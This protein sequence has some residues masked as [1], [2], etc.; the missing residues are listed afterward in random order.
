MVDNN[1][2]I[3]SLS[4][5]EYVE[6]NKFRDLLKKPDNYYSLYFIGS[7][8]EKP[9]NDKKN[10]DSDGF[11]SKYEKLSGC[12]G[13]DQFELERE[14]AKYIKFWHSKDVE[15]QLDYKNDKITQDDFFNEENVLSNILKDKYIKKNYSI[16]PFQLIDHVIGELEKRVFDIELL[17]NNR[18]P[19]LLLNAPLS[20]K[21]FIEFLLNNDIEEKLH[22]LYQGKNSILGYTYVIEKIVVFDLF[23]ILIILKNYPFYVLSRDRLEILFKSLK[24]YK[25]FPYPIGSIGGDLFNLLIHE[26]YLPGVS[27]FQEIRKTLLLDI[28]DPNIIDI[29]PNDFINVVTFEPRIETIVKP[30][31]DE[32]DANNINSKDQLNSPNTNFRLGEQKDLT[33]TTMI[34]FAS[35]ILY[36]SEDKKD[37]EKEEI[38]FENILA[39]FEKRLKQK[40]E[41]LKNSKENNPNIFEKN[42]INN[43]FNLID[44]GLESNFSKFKKEV[45]AFNDE[46]ISKSKESHETTTSKPRDNINLRKFLYHNIHKAELSKEVKKKFKPL[47]KSKSLI[48]N[49]SQKLSMDKRNM[50]NLKKGEKGNK[51]LINSDE[52]EEDQIEDK[53]SLE[54]LENIRILYEYR[55]K[56]LTEKDVDKDEVLED[57]IKNFAEMRKKYFKHLKEFQ[58]DEYK[59]SDDKEK[60][61]MIRNRVIN[62][63]K[64]SRIKEKQLTELYKQK[65]IVKENQLIYFLKNLEVWECNIRPLF[66][67]KLSDDYR[68]NKNNERSENERK[69]EIKDS[70]SVGNEN[71]NIINALDDN[72]RELASA[73]R[74]NVLSQEKD[75]IEHIL[76]SNLP[77]NYELYLIPGEIKIDDRE[78]PDN[79]LTKYIS[80]QDF[81][82]KSII[83]D[84]YW[85]LFNKYKDFNT[86]EDLRKFIDTPIQLYLKES[87]HFFNLK[88]F[89]CKIKLSENQNQTELDELKIGENYY[90]IYGSIHIE[91]FCNL[92]IQLDDETYCINKDEKG[93]KIILVDII[94]IYDEN[95]GKS[96]SEK[97]KYL[98]NPNANNFQVFISFCN[99]E[100]SNKDNKDTRENKDNK[101][102]KE[103]SKQQ[104]T[105]NY[106][107]NKDK[108]DY[109]KR[110][111]IPMMNFDVSSLNFEAKKIIIMPNEDGGSFALTPTF[112]NTNYTEVNYFEINYEKKE[113]LN[114]NDDDLPNTDL[115]VYSFD[116][117]IKTFIDMYK[118]DD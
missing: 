65:Y 61:E 13:P 31:K 50:Q 78:K 108:D 81:I 23:L 41:E 107:D 14:L 115:G 49:I 10:L 112:L 42:I 7:G 46:L 59:F 62:F 116:I 74:N 30:K 60:D 4:K 56:L 16:I 5:D 64:F 36:N 87:Q 33:F 58:V 9:K 103:N 76:N 11:Y 18:D 28:I 63:N 8:R 70:D 80:K 19:N 99:N 88:V 37:S 43:I 22:C 6:F 100:V 29:N 17:Q 114:I 75:T 52:G 97:E 2:D 24:K 35:Y 92:K 44:T 72:L 67:K 40:K 3:I 39:L 26:L 20:D 66:R 82:Y 110:F 117:K 71:L 93:S 95:K 27:L 1:D 45:K 89:Q 57:Y 48:D 109:L 101:E 15:Y 111:V 68:N 53:E 106:N 84:F 21:G 83:G 47:K 51:G 79:P 86:D 104:Y 96:I 98:I 105:V 91:S 69:R 12:S 55:E 118:K 38:Y 54:K 102:K 73:I 113:K 25:S 94:N 85:T 77:F 90:Y 32:N 34:V